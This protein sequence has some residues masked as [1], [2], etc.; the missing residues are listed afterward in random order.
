MK[1]TAL[2]V[3]LLVSTTYSEVRTWTS[4]AGTTI[5]AEFVKEKFGTV[6]LKTADGSVKKIRTSKLISEDQNLILKLADPF[7]E[8]NADEA[9]ATLPKAP[10]AIYALFGDEL[11]NAKKKKVSVDALSGKTIGIYFSAHWCPPC[12]AFTPQLVKFH[13]DMTKKGKP[14]E[15][16]FVSSDKDQSSMYGYMKEMDM[17]WL[18][19]P[20]GDDHKQKLSSK[21]NVKGIPKLVIIAEDGKLI[22]ENGRGDVSSK[23]A[24]A[25]NQWK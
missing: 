15:I 3:A 20:Y 1:T 22:T 10:D 21:F 2:I 8:K 19:L 11:R 24:G 6:Y 7:A 25:F 4:T 17:P 18:A 23:G 14:F 13:N 16:V 9:E 12:R 5:E